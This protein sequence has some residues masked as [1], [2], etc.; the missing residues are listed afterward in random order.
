M[1]VLSP[2]AVLCLLAILVAALAA[3]PVAAG[4]RGDT[5]GV[6]DTARL[7]AFVGERVRRHGLP[8]LA[9][10]VVEGDRIV[11]LRGYGAAD[12][13]RPVTPQTP[14]LL[15]SVS[16][17]LTATAVMQLVEAGRVELDAPV[18]RYLPD[19]RMA[20][21]DAS[22]RITV[23]HL[24][25]HTSG[26]PLTACDTRAEAATLAE[27]AA[28]L[29]TVALAAEPGARHRYCSGNYN[30]LGRVVEVVSGQPFG[31][32]MQRQVFAPL[33]MRHAFADERA[34]QRAGLARGHRCSSGRPARPT[35]ATT[36][37]SCPRAS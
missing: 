32:Y 26:L 20:D 3:Q 6:I 7:D 37:R 16:K 31:D 9:L 29:R 23:R 15:A 34:A 17:P 27:Y 24:L 2:G 10:G 14:F 35:S 18:V 5:P 36:P 30:L 11:H 12:S 22:A 33:A 1:H 13:A 8:G 19:F 21:P 4:S 28:E 25:Q